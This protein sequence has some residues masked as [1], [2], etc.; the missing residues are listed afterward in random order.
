MILLQQGATLITGN[1]RLS[2][3]MR[4][5]YDSACR[6]SGKRLWE[7]PDILPR[8][9]WLRRLWNECA[10]EDPANTPV[11]LDAAQERALWEQAVAESSAESGGE[12]G[13]PD[14]AEYLLNIPSTASIAA[15]AWDLLHAWELPRNEAACSGLP[16]AEMFLIWR[17]A[18]ERTLR[19]KNWLT[20]SQLPQALASRFA[21]GKTR[22]S[23]PIY[24]AGFDEITPIDQQLFG[25]IRET[26]C[27][28]SEFPAVAGHPAPRQYRAAF[29]NTSDELLHAASWARSKLEQSPGAVI[30]IIVHGLASMRAAVERIFDD[31]LH[32][33]VEFTPSD[34]PRAFHISAGALVADAPL[35]ATALQVLSLRRGLPLPEAGMLLRSPFLRLGAA[36]GAL[37]DA[38]FR[39]RGMAEVTIRLPLMRR[40]LEAFA[41]AL[42]ELPSRQRPSQWSASFSELLRHAGWPGD[43]TLS[44][45]E[46]QTLERCNDLLSEFAQLDPLIRSLDY[47][48]ALSRLRRLAAESQF[49]PRDEGAPVQVMDMLEAAGSRF[50]FLW[51]VGLHDRAWPQPPRP[52]PFLPV[53][54]QRAA[55]VPQC[56]AERELQYARR[57]TGRLLSSAQEVICSCPL[58]SAEEK[59]RV[60]PLIAHLPEM[61]PVQTAVITVSQALFSTARRLEE[62][63]TEV[64][65]AL[66]A[67]WE[68]SGGVQ[69]LADQAACPFRSFAVHR[70]AARGLE[71]P[72]LGLSPRERGNILHV[73]MKLIWEEL[74][75]QDELK[76]RSQDDVVALIR[77]RVR[78]ALEDT[79]NPRGSAAL[80]RFQALEEQ[81]LV[82]LLLQWLEVE[83]QQRPPFEVLDME[84]ASIV[85][86]GGLK[87]HIKADRIDRYL[88]DG[89]CAIIDYKTSK[90]ISA[91]DWEGNRPDE[92]Q[93]PLYAATIDRPVS[94][95]L[96]AKIVAGET[97]LIGPSEVGDV[98]HGRQ[99][100]ASL[101]ERIEEWRRIL[102]ELAASFQQGNAAVDPKRRS[103]T[104]R[105]CEITPLCRIAEIERGG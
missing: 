17:S 45:A 60:S 29:Q 79:L 8:E 10:Y 55:G 92:P 42:E 51:V 22:S 37:L 25:A 49:A 63:R 75:T 23:G 72:E 54:L 101:A 87:L 90:N 20:L 33:G 2:R 64:A 73:A 97:H 86:L 83:K 6:Q 30:G 68:Q 36:Q 62:V 34:A 88:A 91:A 102:E 100:S 81:R 66:P 105:H 84:K 35:V 78:L 32:P 21:E 59:L 48:E 85:E 44:Q 27:D 65:P 28:V 1:V 77:R 24:Y 76:A 39:R 7:S 11:L 74:K 58:Y 104:C 3:R 52:N 46:F 94:A 99:K 12:A 70:L 26:G 82:R 43:R 89:G 71:K 67:G 5:E 40:H 61:E 93:L 18:V 95:V 14:A 103:Q 9:S 57:I 56:S 47:D 4:R 53:T 16:D 41:R 98:T 80:Q 38:E 69:V 13:Q 19:E 96:F 31:V 50:D 15:R